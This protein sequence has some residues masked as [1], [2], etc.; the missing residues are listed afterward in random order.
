[1]ITDKK[2]ETFLDKMIKAYKQK[3]MPKVEK[4]NAEYEELTLSKE[5][6]DKAP[7]NAFRAFTNETQDDYEKTV[8]RRC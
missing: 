2:L 1:M 7:I 4:L 3:D 6:Q 5:E 8:G